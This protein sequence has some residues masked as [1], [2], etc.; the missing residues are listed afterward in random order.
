MFFL[1]VKQERRIENKVENI[2]YMPF[3]KVYSKI[4]EINS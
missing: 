1:L 2:F 4:R 3:R